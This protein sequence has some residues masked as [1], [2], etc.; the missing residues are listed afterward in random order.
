MVITL[1]RPSASLSGRVVDAGGQ[2]AGGALVAHG[3]QTTRADEHGFFTIYLPDEADAAPTDVG[4]RGAVDAEDT[5]QPLLVAVLPGHQPAKLVATVDPDSGERVWPDPLQ[6]QLGPAPRTLGGLVTD[7]EGSPLPHMKVWLADPTVLVREPID[8]RFQNVELSRDQPGATRWFTLVEN[9]LAG[10]PDEHWHAVMTDAEGRFDIGGLLDR[11]YMLAAMNPWTLARTRSEPLTAG[12]DDVVLVLDGGD[13]INELTGHVVDRFGGPVAGVYL[14]MRADAFSA[15]GTT[16]IETRSGAVTAEDGAFTLRG[17]PR[18]GVYLR[19]AGE[20]VIPT[21][22]GRDA[23]GMARLGEEPGGLRFVVPLRLD[24]QVALA[25]PDEADRLVVLDAAGEVLPLASY[26][27]G[28]RASRG[29]APITDGRSTIF[30][31][32]DAAATL[33][34][35]RDGIEVRREPLRLNAGGLNTIR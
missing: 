17:V 24:V 15:S 4:T 25:D 18:E 20:H 14:V 23:D 12:R 3:L 21:V 8:P 31:V 19:A 13:L 7:A 34:L 29:G 2:A 16:F 22:H 6:L 5:A 9:T 26:S 33:V 35:S 32:S 30:A 28:R 27:F 1:D 11:D 10:A